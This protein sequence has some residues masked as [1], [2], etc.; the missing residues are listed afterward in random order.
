MHGGGSTGTA[1]ARH[2]SKLAWALGLTATYMIAEVIGGLVTGSLALL[3]DADVFALASRFEGYGMV[4]AEALSQGLP[5]VACRAGA[6]PE[7]VP[8]DAGMLVPVDDVSAFARA[9]RSLVADKSLRRTK[10][11]AARRAGASLP[12][13]EVTV[14]IIAQALE[15][16]R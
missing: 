6:V 3:A 13:W 8:E 10:A 7:V 16:L 15:T 5:I 2:A 1:G 11:T 4:F 12:G 9:L 14:G